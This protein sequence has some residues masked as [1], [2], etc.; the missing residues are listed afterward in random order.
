MTVTWNAREVLTHEIGTL[1]TA[2]SEVTVGENRVAPDMTVPR[3]TGRIYG[4]VGSVH[5][6]SVSGPQ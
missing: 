5:G 3:F 4:V 1:V 6:V 2:P